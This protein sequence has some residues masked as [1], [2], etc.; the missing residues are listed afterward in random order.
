MP[1]SLTIDAV[2]PDWRIP[3]VDTVK[4]PLM[5]SVW[6]LVTSDET[7]AAALVKLPVSLLWN[8]AVRELA[9]SRKLP[10]PE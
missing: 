7:V 5:V 2:P 1:L 10:A 4:F 6:L 3:P 9:A 8:V